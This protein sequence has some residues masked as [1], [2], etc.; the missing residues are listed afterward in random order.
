M[1]ARTKLKTFMRNTWAR[2]AAFLV[3]RRMQY[4]SDSPLDFNRLMEQPEDWLLVMP[5]EANAFDLAI[6]NCKDF[7]SRIEGVRMHLLVPYEFRYWEKTTAILKVYPY[8]R[9]DLVL[10]RFPRQ[11]LMQRIAKLK[12][13]VALDLCPYPTPLSLTASG[14]SGARVRGSLSRKQGDGIFNLLIKSGAGNIEDRYNALF[15]Y[16]S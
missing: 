16:L 9:H 2:I 10:G 12:P 15:S 7:L 3:M 11:E 5:A 14:L 8:E 13:A 4:A 1:S 6:R